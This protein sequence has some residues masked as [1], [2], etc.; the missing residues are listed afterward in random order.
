MYTKISRKCVL[1]RFDGCNK[2]SVNIIRMIKGRRMRWAGHVASMKA[3][4]MCTKFRLESLKTID[5]LE[6]ICVDGQIILK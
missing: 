4:K 5:H 3:I 1:D 2:T 6:D